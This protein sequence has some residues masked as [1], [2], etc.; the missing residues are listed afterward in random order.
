MP[1]SP[2][3]STPPPE[4]TGGRGL[5]RQGDAAGQF[6]PVLTNDESWQLIKTGE[7]VNEEGSKTQPIRFRAG[8]TR[9]RQ[10]KGPSCIFRWGPIWNHGIRHGVPQPI[11]VGPGPY[12]E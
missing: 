5:D 10:A 7:T 1:A 6:L 12:G 11:C 3:S 4:T 2:P 8:L 9:P